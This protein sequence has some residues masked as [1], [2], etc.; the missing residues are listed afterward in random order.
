M[1][2]GP[3][4]NWTFPNLKA[5][6][7]SAEVYLGVGDGVEPVSHKSS[8]KRVSITLDP[9]FTQQDNY[10]TTMQ[11]NSPFYYKMFKSLGSGFFFLQ[12]FW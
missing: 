2:L 11:S 12:C 10:S 8:F 1:K 4:K 6:A 7:E 3:T 9:S 5:S